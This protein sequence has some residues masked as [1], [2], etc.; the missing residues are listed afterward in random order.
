MSTTPPEPPGVSLVRVAPGS[1]AST[2]LPPSLAPLRPP[3]PRKGL[4]RVR[5]GQ[6]F[7]AGGLVMALLLLAAVILSALAF[8]GNNQARD[9]LIDQVDPAA[10]QQFQITSA[11]DEQDTAIRTFVRS[12]RRGD[13]AAYREAVTAE[14]QAIATMRRLLVGV[15][16]AEE[17]QVRLERATAATA[18]WRTR[19]AV[20]LAAGARLTPAHNEDGRLLF[21]EA[22]AANSA[23]QRALTELHRTYD[24]Q[25]R[26]KARTLYVSL[27]FTGVVIVVVAIGMV[28]LIR[29]TVLRPVARL[30]DQVRAVSQG[31]FAHPLRISGPAEL[32][33]LAGIVDSMRHRIVQEWRAT[34]EARQ[35]AAEQAAE[36]RRSNAELEQFAYVAS[37]DLQEPLRKVASFCQMIERR[38]GDQLDDRGRR[39]IEFAV[40]G[41]KRMQALI[42]DLLTL[43]RVGRSQR[44]EQEVDLNRALARAMDDLEHAIDETGAQVT[45]DDLPTVTGDRTLLAL[46]F[47]NLV[48]NAIKFHGEDPPLVRIAVGRSEED[49]DGPDMWEFSCTDNGIGIDP[50]YAERIFLIFQ[51]LHPQDTYTGTGIG[52]AMCKKIVEYHG[53]RIWLDPGHE[54]PGTTFRW[55]LPAQRAAATG[56][57][58]TDVT[59][60]DGT[61]DE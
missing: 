24:G 34:S 52:L 8:Q 32:A 22:G 28:I 20:P 47:Q 60:G 23:T 12:R 49:D 42:N 19:F 17:A 48:G 44:V 5:L 13:L 40:D 53:G 7:S 51:R 39:Y 46:L 43:S 1:F 35:I 27:A 30:T 45:A 31:D 41:S 37:H 58:T 59:E 61:A 3:A 14:S 55:T 57:A 6:W 4:S 10:L 38:Y 18:A 11:L 15:S 36:L 26:D 25:L 54:G 2:P 9:T 33:E 50:K 21:R 56:R 29:R 16:G